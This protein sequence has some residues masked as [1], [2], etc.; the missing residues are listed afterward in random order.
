MVSQRQHSGQVIFNAA[1]KTL[2]RLDDITWLDVNCTTH[3]V[4]PRIHDIVV[5]F[6]LDSILRLQLAATKQ[7]STAESQPIRGSAYPSV[8][9]ETTVSYRIQCSP[10]SKAL[11]PPRLEISTPNASYAIQLT[12]ISNNST[13]TAPLLVH[14]DT[15]VEWTSQDIQHVMRTAHPLDNTSTVINAELEEE[16][17]S[18]P[19]TI[20]IPLQSTLTSPFTSDIIT[21]RRNGIVGNEQQFRIFLQNRYRRSLR[22]VMHDIC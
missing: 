16:S 14:F 19:A 3:R 12:Y 11:L 10:Y 5:T 17:I 7:C 1:N 22:K 13:R 18:R 8:S 9:S 15:E 21:K 6:V 2:V 4:H 20:G